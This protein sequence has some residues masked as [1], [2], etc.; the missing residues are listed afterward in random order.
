M[1]KDFNQLKADLERLKSQ[2]QY[3]IASGLFQEMSEIMSES[4]D[5]CPVKFGRLKAT[6]QVE[7]PIIMSGRTSC[8]MGYSTKYAIY[9]HEILENYHAPPTKA[10]FLE[11][12]VNRNIDK[13]P[14]FI[15]RSIAILMGGI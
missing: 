8:R 2:H 6:G 7:E 10:K 11:D 1:I 12:P 3:A 5:E 14:Q 9:V 15:N 4:H 13:V